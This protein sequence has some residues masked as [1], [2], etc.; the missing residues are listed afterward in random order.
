MVWVP[1]T[2][3]KLDLLR[4][5]YEKRCAHDRKFN[6]EALYTLVY[7]DGTEVLTLPDDLNRMF[8]LDEYHKDVGK[9]FNRITL[10][11]LKR[12]EQELHNQLQQDSSDDTDGDSGPLED[13]N[14]RQ[15]SVIESFARAGSCT[16]T[17]APSQL[18][19]QSTNRTSLMTQLD[20][21]VVDD[22]RNDQNNNESEENCFDVQ[23]VNTLPSEATRSSRGIQ[24]LNEIIPTKSENELRLAL[25]VTI[26]IRC[27][28]LFLSCWTTTTFFVLA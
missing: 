14:I 15:I 22:H 21:A 8:Q 25:D 3:R 7:P 16:Q 5:S 26:S 19:V 9:S 1:A 6:K 24:S 10:F 23:V 28:F 12:S 20:L 17:S 4:V 27:I 13:N 2:I 11:L 18:I